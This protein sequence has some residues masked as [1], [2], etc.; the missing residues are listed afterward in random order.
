M[1]TRHMMP[2]VNEILRV[3]KDNMFL[4]SSLNDIISNIVKRRYRRQYTYLPLLSASLNNH[5]LDEMNCRYSE[6]K[7]RG[8]LGFHLNQDTTAQI[9]NSKKHRTQR[10]WRQ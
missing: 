5:H 7:L 3:G 9:N 4:A 8:Q 6:H 10:R 1:I 2:S